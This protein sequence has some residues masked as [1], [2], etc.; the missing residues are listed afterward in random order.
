MSACSSGKGSPTSSSWSTS[1]ADDDYVMPSP[2]LPPSRPSLSPHPTN[3]TPLMEGEEPLDVTTPPPPSRSE[4][5]KVFDFDDSDD[6]GD[7]SSP[8]SGMVVGVASR[9]RAMPPPAK[10]HALSVTTKSVPPVSRDDQLATQKP[11][12]RVRASVTGGGRY[13][14]V[15]SKR[16][17]TAEGGEAV[18]GVA[19]KES[20]GKGSWQRKYELKAERRSGH[21]AP[22]SSSQQD[23]SG[24]ER[25]EP[26]PEKSVQSSATPTQNSSLATPNKTTPPL[27]TTTPPMPLSST[28]AVQSHDPILD[29]HAPSSSSGVSSSRGGV[30]SSGGGVSMSRGA[31]S[32]SVGGVSTSRGGVSSSRTGIS[33]S[34]GGVSSSVGGVSLSGGGVSS[35]RGKVSSSGGGVSSR[36]EVTS[37][38]GGVSSLRGGVS[39]SRGGVSS[40]RG[41][42]GKSRTCTNNTASPLLKETRTP[43]P[44]SGHAPSSSDDPYAF[45]PDAEDDATMEISSVRPKLVT[46]KPSQPRAKTDFGSGSLKFGT[47][48]DVPS[49]ST[50]SLARAVLESRA[51]KS[52]SG[53]STSP[54]IESGSNSRPPKSEPKAN[55]SNR[56]RKQEV[57]GANSSPVKSKPRPQSD[58]GAESRKASDSDDMLREIDSLLGEGI[59]GGASTGVD[60]GVAVGRVNRT[61]SD[62]FNALDI[63]SGNDHG[64]VS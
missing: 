51:S 42:V 19:K 7:K 23:R 46:R 34:R 45:D 41:V 2:P 3:H 37:S 54:L 58:Q 55:Y 60:G 33:L 16:A 49:S 32:S 8:L 9:G 5:L 20:S 25:V 26:I 18:G 39:S 1:P 57:G 50:S 10:R 22:S 11:V 30:S 56:K 47:K 24:L 61:S 15:A 40:S 17:R 44:P 43:P 53:T 62:A 4:R 28:S 13:V 64:K 27:N 31:V 6:D 38:R 48:K 21:H 12:R 63:A 35:S 29:R 36:G 14:D 59:R 52:S